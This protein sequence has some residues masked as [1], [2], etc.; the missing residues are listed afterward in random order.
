MNM[1]KSC[2]KWNTFA[3]SFSNNLGLINLAPSKDGGTCKRELIGKEKKMHNLITKCE[4][5]RV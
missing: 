3:K 4:K 5:E 2:E 1:M